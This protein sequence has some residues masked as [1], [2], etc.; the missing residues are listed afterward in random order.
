MQLGRLPRQAKRW[1]ET[2]SR[3]VV[4]TQIAQTGNFANLSTRQTESNPRGCET[5]ACRCYDD[6]LAIDGCLKTADACLNGQLLRAL[7]EEGISPLSL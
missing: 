4:V 1:V 5:S 6:A 7:A 2:G 3:R